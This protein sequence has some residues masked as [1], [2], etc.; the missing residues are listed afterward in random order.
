MGPFVS[1]LLVLI[2]TYTRY[3]AAAIVA[4]A[5]VAVAALAAGAAGAA[6]PTLPTLAAAALAAAGIGEPAELALDPFD[7]LERHQLLQHPLFH[8]G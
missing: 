2:G 5:D 6:L 8:S 4:A 1:E 3:P 7:E